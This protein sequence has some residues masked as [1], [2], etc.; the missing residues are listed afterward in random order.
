MDSLA[1]NYCAFFE[2]ILDENSIPDL[3]LNKYGLINLNDKEIKKIKTL[4]MKRL[5]LEE[6]LSY[7][8]IGQKFNLSDSG[9]YRRIQSYDNRNFKNGRIS[10]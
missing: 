10:V 8:K 2:A 7:K 6:K 4:E 5:H 3:I 1:Y 9:V